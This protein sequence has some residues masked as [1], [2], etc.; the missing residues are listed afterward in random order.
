MYDPAFM[1]NSPPNLYAPE[2]YIKKAVYY[3]ATAQDFYDDIPNRI[4]EV[5]GKKCLHLNGMTYVADSIE[6]PPPESTEFSEGTFNI[7]G[8]GGI[9]CGGNAIMNGHV[10]QPFEPE[11]EREAETP[12]T[13][14]SLIVR[15]GG[16]IINETPENTVFEGSL[17]TDKGIAVPADKSI[18]I[19]GNWVTNR[20]SKADTPGDI[21][22][23]YVAYKTRSSL[24]S[25]NPA[26][27]VF[28]PERYVVSMAPGY[29]SVRVQ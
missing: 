18:R 27:G 12:R 8:R 10:R 9:V 1:E 21:R 5:N 2:Q 17:Y 19:I 3:Y 22:I 13:V 14:F 11:A 26:T 29:V 24:N 7:F 4:I 23:E 20:F 16:L 6:L 15:K 25:V 28:D